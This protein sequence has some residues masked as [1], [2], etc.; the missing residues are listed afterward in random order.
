MFKTWIALHR[1][2]TAHFFYD[3]GKHDDVSA[4]LQEDTTGDIGIYIEYFSIR[5]YG[6]SKVYGAMTNA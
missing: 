2:L 4:L 1:R 3:S 5:R 6:K